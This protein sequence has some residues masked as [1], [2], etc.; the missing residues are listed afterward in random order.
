MPFVLIAGL[1][2]NPSYYWMA[3]LHEGW[4]M[5]LRHEDKRRKVVF[6]ILMFHH[7]PQSLFTSLHDINT[8][9]IAR[10]VDAEFAAVGLKFVYHLAEGIVDTHR[11]EVFAAES[12]EVI[13]GIREEIKDL[14]GVFIYIERKIQ[15]EIDFKIAC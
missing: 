11:A 13:S 4:R 15:N 6:S 14:G 2:R 1:T 3:I 8:V 10:R 12:C 7:K 5:F 9:F